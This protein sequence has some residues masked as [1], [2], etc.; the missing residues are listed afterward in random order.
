MNVGL[1]L[2]LALGPCGVYG[3][4]FDFATLFAGGEKGGWFDPNTASCLFQDTAGTVPVTTAADPVGRWNASN[5]TFTPLLQATAGL[6]PVYGV[7]GNGAKY[8]DF[9]ATDD[10]LAS[11]VQTVNTVDA[12]TI[13]VGVKFRTASAGGVLT[14]VRAGSASGSN[15]ARGTVPANGRFLFTHQGSINPA[16]VPQVDGYTGAQT[17]VVSA[18]GKIATDLSELYING[19]LVDSDTADQGTGNYANGAMLIGDLFNNSI[20]GQVFGALW[21]GRLLTSGERASVE[22]YL[23][24]KLGI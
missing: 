24:T 17:L 8:V 4:S 12:C 10:A 20:D 22:A 5:G 16:T 6:R 23:A 18:R 2:S 13:V 21:I 9:D 3:S 14:G 7:A 1:S 15:L 19:T 11:A